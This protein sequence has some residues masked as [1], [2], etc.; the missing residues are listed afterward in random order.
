MLR[1]LGCLS[2][3]LF[4]IATF[5]AAPLASAAK[6]EAATDP[7][8]ADAD[9]AYQGEYSGE[10]KGGDQ[11]L[12][13]GVQVIALG[14]GKFHAVGHHGG[15]PGDGWDG[16]DKV[17]A[18]GELK[19]GVVT[20]K[21]AD[22]AVGEIKGGVLTVK[23]SGGDT[24]G[25][26]KKVE[27]E[28]PTIGAKPPKDAIVLFDGTSGDKFN[29]GK[30]KVENGLLVPRAD[31]DL[32]FQDCKLHVEFRLAYQPYDRGQGRSNSGVYLQGRYEIQVLDS[33]GLKGESNECGGIYTIKPPLV[34]MCFPP[35][36]W[37]TYDVDYTAAK[38]DDKGKKTENAKITVLQNGVL[39][40][41]QTE[42]PH[43][44]TAAPVAEG[45]EPGPLHLQD[46]GSPVRF[47]NI[48]IVL[49]K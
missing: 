17:E 21:S 32:K 41:D 3:G 25:A 27:R 2:L 6:G 7:A 24:I 18:D 31:S 14:D 38:Y 35:L 46:H 20:I 28:S 12:K 30:G 40:Q 48:W 10:I 8:K 39:I 22:G 9:F 29:N 37:Q 19:D 34:N 44:T 15:L 13:V 42:I 45:P 43:G 49:K 1:R 23:T 4:L 5:S 36:S 47:R 33:F 11:A 26:L 16:K